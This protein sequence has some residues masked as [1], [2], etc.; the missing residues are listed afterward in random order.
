M[1]QEANHQKR[2]RIGR[3]RL[4]AMEILEI[5]MNASSNHHARACITFSHIGL[6]S[7]EAPRLG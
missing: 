3:I 2:R 1:G 4:K 5:H 7:E 6:H